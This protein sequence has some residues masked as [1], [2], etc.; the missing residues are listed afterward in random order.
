MVLSSPP[1]TS[2]LQVTWQALP[3]E[4]LLPDDPVENLQQPALAA[5]LSDALNQAGRVPAEALMGT[6]FALVATVNGKTIVKAPDWFY[7][8]FA[9]P[10]DAQVIRRSYTPYLQGDGVAVV[11]EFL[12]ET[13]GGEL[14]VRSTVPYGKLYFYEQILQVPVYVTFDPYVPSLE[15]RCLDQGRYQLQTSD[16]HGRFWLPPLD[17]GLGIWSGTYQQLTGHWLRWWDGAGE[18]LPWSSEQAEQERQ[19][20]EQERQRAEQER[21]RAERLAAVLR[22]RGIDPDLL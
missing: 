3:D 5:A 22:D 17:L 15:V 21:Q 9:H 4:F 2:S 18:L 12:S 19:R 14:S 16:A 1:S 10:I 6:N 11:M 8:P 7:I 20:A 13:E